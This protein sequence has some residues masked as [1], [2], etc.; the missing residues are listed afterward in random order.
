[1]NST[2][3]GGTPELRPDDALKDTLCDGHYVIFMNGW[4]YW[5]TE[6][7]LSGNISKMQGKTL[8]NSSACFRDV[9]RLMKKKKTKYNR[10]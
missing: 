5:K 2:N 8:Q 10:N 4:T 7:E 3:S 9:L 1:M 6:E